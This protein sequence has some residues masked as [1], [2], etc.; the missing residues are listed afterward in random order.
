[1]RLVLA[2]GLAAGLA[3]LTAGAVQAETRV[4]L[5]IGN[6]Q[7]TAVPTLPNPANDASLIAKSLKQIGFTVTLKK[8]VNKAALEQSLQDFSQ[9][10]ENSDVALIYYAGHGVEVGGTNYLVPIDAKLAKERDVDFEAVSLPSVLRTLEGAHQL[11]MVVLDAC[12]NNP[13]KM[14]PSGSS[15]RAI[16]QRGL[17]RVEPAGD[18]LVAYAAKEGTTASDGQDNSPFAKA[19]ASELAAPGLDVRLMFGRVRDD[20]LSA[21]G[22]AQEPYLYGS[23]GGSAFYLVPPSETKAVA[24]AAV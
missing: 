2:A 16:G 12:R 9:S 13:F 7:Y 22:K 19:L 17:A 24:P 20:V 5:V 11:R 3:V 4:A 15:V 18:T 1:M 10:V 6:A 23:L 21:T 14:Q 8:N